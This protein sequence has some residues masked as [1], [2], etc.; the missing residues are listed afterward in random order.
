MYTHLYDMKIGPSDRCI[1]IRAVGRSASATA[2]VAL[3]AGPIASKQEAG[4]AQLQQQSTAWMSCV[5]LRLIY[6]VTRQSGRLAYWVAP[7]HRPT[8][9]QITSHGII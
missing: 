1:N 7:Y 3:Q 9:W 6:T 2:G 5:P 4:T 8:E